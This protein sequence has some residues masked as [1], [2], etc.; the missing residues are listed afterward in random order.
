MSARSRRRPR[1]RPYIVSV[2]NHWR[3]AGPEQGRQVLV[4]DW[5]GNLQ[6]IYVPDDHPALVRFLDR[7]AAAVAA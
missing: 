2:S 5:D 1:Q 7:A 6:T 3:V 4:R